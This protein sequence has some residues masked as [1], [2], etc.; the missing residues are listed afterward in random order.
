MANEKK[1]H[2]GSSAKAMPAT[3]QA[4]GVEKIIQD[5]TNRYRVTAREARDIVTAVGTAQQAGWAKNRKDTANTGP[6]GK[7]LIKQVGETVKAATTGKKGTTSDVV[8]AKNVSG[9]QVLSGY[10]KGKKRS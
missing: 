6:A 2:K 4:S 5:V 3:K 8:K 7:N 1:L 9:G 10:E